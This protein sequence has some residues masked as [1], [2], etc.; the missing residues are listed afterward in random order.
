MPCPFSPTIFTILNTGPW[1]MVAKD[2]CNIFLYNGPD[3]ACILLGRPPVLCGQLFSF[4]LPYAHHSAAHAP[5]TAQHAILPAQ[6]ATDTTRARTTTTPRTTSLHGYHTCHSVHSWVHGLPCLSY[7]HMLPVPAPSGMPAVHSQAG[8]A[9]LQWAT[10][11]QPYSHL[12]L[13]YYTAT[14][15]Y[16]CLHLTGEPHPTYLPMPY[17]SSLPGTG[18]QCLGHGGAGWAGERRGAGRRRGRKRALP[19]SRAYCFPAT[20]ALPQHNMFRCRATCFSPSRSAYLCRYYVWHAA[21]PL[22]AAGY[23]QHCTVCMTGL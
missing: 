6:G 13:S 10:P 12:Q 1:Q 17:P 21:M 15:A 2:N 16:H 8:R 19:T 23:G 5:R 22:P 11:G 9:R 3:L 7:T 20:T 14:R 4:T 18:G